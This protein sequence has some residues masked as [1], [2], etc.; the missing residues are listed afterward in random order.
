MNS[1]PYCRHGRY[2]GGSGV[3]WLG[4]TMCGACEMDYSDDTPRE[5][6]ADVERL[7][8]SLETLDGRITEYAR[9]L[10]NVDADKMIAEIR[11]P[12]VTK[13]LAAADEF[14]RVLTL[15]NGNMDDNQWLIRQH[16]KDVEAYYE[17]ERESAQREYEY[18]EW[19]REQREMERD[20]IYHNR[21]W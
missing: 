2:I 6:L 13:L 7:A 5:L 9:A 15:C 21:E 16:D 3:D 14:S 17:H 4:N 18:N 8:L 11:K 1:Y 19:L 12:Y 20:D 10:P